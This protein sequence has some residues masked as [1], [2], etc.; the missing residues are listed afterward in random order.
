MFTSMIVHRATLFG[1]AAF[2]SMCVAHVSQTATRDPFASGEREAIGQ[3]PTPLPTIPP[4]TPP[5]PPPPTPPLPAPMP[6]HHA[7]RPPHSVRA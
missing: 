1:L 5:L 7:P 2:G 6:S 3:T 4:P